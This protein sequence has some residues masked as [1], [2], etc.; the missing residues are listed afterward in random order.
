MNHDSLAITDI[1]DIKK[2]IKNF[3]IL[4]KQH[5]DNFEKAK[6]KYVLE[7]GEEEVKVRYKLFFS[8]K[9]KIKDIKTESQILRSGV[10]FGGAWISIEQKLIK[11]KYVERKDIKYF[12]NEKFLD[13]KNQL[14]DL[15]NTS[16]K[17]YVIL[18]TSL[19]NFISEF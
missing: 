14:M 3:D 16:S 6:K 7:K 9:V 18:G 13:R 4:F 10:S 15:I 5:E 1:E 8:K 17:K 2:S 11:L 19:A 12:T